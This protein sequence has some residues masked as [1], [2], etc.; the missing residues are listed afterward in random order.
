MNLSNKLLS[1]IVAF[2]TY[3]RYI[4]HLSRRE[5]LEETINRNMIMHLDRFPMLSRDI[6]KAYEQVHELKV[7]PSMRALQFGGEAI[8]KNNCRLYN[9]SALNIDDQQAFS[10]LLYLLLSGTGVGYSV[11]RVHV[12]K[13]PKIGLPREE[14]IFP[15]Q[16]S[17]AGWAQA[18]DALTQ[19]YFYSRVRPVFDYSKIRPKGARLV[20]TGAKAPGPEPLKHML[21]EVEKR[22]RM[23]QGRRLRPI[24]AHDILCLVSDCVLAGGVRRSAMISLFDRDDQE[25]LKSKSGDWWD[26]HPYRARANNSAVLPRKDVTKE[27]FE[28]LFRSCEESKAGE[29]GFLWTNNTEL[30]TNPCAEISL[31]SNSFC[32]LTTVNQ[33]G[34]T[35]KGDFLRR[36]Q[37]A[38][39]IGTIQATYTDFPYLRPIWKETTEKEYLIGVS[40]T[41][42]A[43]ANGIVTKA[44]LE[45]GARLVREVNEKFA[46]KLGILPAARCTTVKPEGTSSAVLGSS[47]GIHPRHSRYYLRRIRMNKIDVLGKYLQNTIPSL[48][49]D[50]MLSNSTIVVTIPQE[51]PE[52]AITRHDEDCLKFLERVMDY[53]VHWIKPGHKSGDN[54]NNVSCTVSVKDDEWGK[55]GEFMWRHRGLYSG[56]SLLPFD[57]GNYKQPPFEECDKDIYEKYMTMV[58]DIDLKEVIEVEDFTNH[59]EHAACAGGACELTRV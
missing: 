41:G 30:L 55:V 40:F 1:E 42:I 6:I 46:K 34:I 59:G 15:I 37:A 44:W 19:A 38:T 22:L 17:I 18:I 23:A 51:A 5:V 14:G 2:R 20:T 52:G 9:C 10:E 26:K 4:P 24:E 43:D 3:A 54:C 33:T 27:E 45:E 28:H 53:N 16:D 8:N 35:D 32:N 21:E 12:N 56:I 48:I 49:E 7:M 13:L 57:G 25:M 36:V 50:D 29:P 47:S 31:P 11:Q 58:K 39:V